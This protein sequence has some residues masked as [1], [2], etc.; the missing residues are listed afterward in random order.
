M[1][2]GPVGN[3]S[4][5]VTRLA[6]G[7]DQ[8]PESVQV[9]LDI[10]VDSSASMLAALRDGSIEEVCNIIAGIATVVSPQKNPRICM[11]GDTPRWIEVESLRDLG[12][13]VVHELHQA[14]LVAGFRSSSVPNSGRPGATS[15]FVITDGVPADTSY[16][17]ANQHF[18][19]IMSETESIDPRW[20]DDITVVQPPSAGIRAAVHLSS[21]RESLAVT[22]R[23]LVRSAV[24]NGVGGAQ[25][26]VR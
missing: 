25:A 18:V 16:G 3:I 11:V 5:S 7:V 20:A 14:L 15:T 17:P 2:L 21:S 24:P 10:A 8:L 13:T 1:D 6:L 23:S 26:V 12:S 19:A 22:V 9:G 4:R